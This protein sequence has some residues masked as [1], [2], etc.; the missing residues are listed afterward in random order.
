MLSAVTVGMVGYLV[1]AYIPPNITTSRIPLQ[2]IPHYVL[3]VAHIFTATVASL[4]GIVQ[5]W[6]WIRRRHPAVHRWTGRAYLFLDVF[7]SVLIAVPVAV[8]A[9]FGAANQAALL[10]L[11]VL[12]I[13]TGIAAYR[14][15]RQ[16]RIADHR[17]W[18]VRNFALT[19]AAIATRFFVPV[20]LL[21]IIPQSGSPNYGNDQLVI[22]HDTASDSAWLGLVVTMLVAERYTKPRRR[23]PASNTSIDPPVASQ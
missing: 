4:T 2:G 10:T 17:R 15:I 5:F 11:D 1:S 6:P 16:H 20:M 13:A 14:A 22:A 9:P 18:M 3:L 21:V 7:P 19:F 12:W 23:R 8:L